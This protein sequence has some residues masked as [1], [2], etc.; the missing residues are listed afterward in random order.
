MRRAVAYWS[1]LYPDEAPEGLNDRDALRA[2]STAMDEL[3][4]RRSGA[5]FVHLVEE[6]MDE[7]PACTVTTGIG[8]EGQ[9]TLDPRMVSGC[10]ECLHA[11]ALVE[12]IRRVK[13]RTTSR[14]QT[15]QDRSME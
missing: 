5:P 15:P 13:P 1:I 6:K 14:E 4:N 2:A 12:E 3:E 9:R 11:V 7:T 10:P 8:V